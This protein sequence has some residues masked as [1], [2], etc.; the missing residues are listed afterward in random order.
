MTFLEDLYYSTDY[1]KQFVVSHV[2]IHLVEDSPLGN[3]WD[4]LKVAK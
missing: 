1:R 2:T 3:F 4:E